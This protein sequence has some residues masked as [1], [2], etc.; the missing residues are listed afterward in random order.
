MSAETGA[1]NRT[2]RVPD[3]GQRP[4]LPMVGRAAAGECHYE[5][6]QP[7]IYDGRSIAWLEE[8]EQA[9]FLGRVVQDLTDA[10]GR[11][12]VVRVLVTWEDEAP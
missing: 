11:A 5:R 4:W 9:T 10:L 2:M 12:R 3:E 7:A 1:S 8:E 6:Y